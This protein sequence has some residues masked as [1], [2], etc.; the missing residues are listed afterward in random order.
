[1]IRSH[2]VSV[3]H[4]DFQCSSFKPM[5]RAIAGV[6]DSDCRLVSRLESIKHCEHEYGDR[7]GASFVALCFTMISRETKLV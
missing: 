3:D 2:Q 4:V 7:N 1:M 6:A 5:D